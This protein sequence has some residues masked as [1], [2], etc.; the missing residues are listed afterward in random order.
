MAEVVWME[1]VSA[2]VSA[3]SFLNGSFFLGFSKSLS[4]Q[5]VETSTVSRT[6]NWA[7]SKGADLP[8]SDQ[9]LQNLKSYQTCQRTRG[10]M[11]WACIVPLFR[12]FSGLHICLH[13]FNSQL[14]SKW[15]SECSSHFIQR[16]VVPFHWAQMLVTRCVL[17]S[18][19][20][21]AWT[22]Y[23]TCYWE[24]KNRLPRKWTIS[25]L[26]LAPVFIREK[27]VCPLML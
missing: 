16:G 9:P 21:S 20:A 3:S 8:T 24:I 10:T 13:S 22:G 23:V 26:Y 6:E 4:S 17:R 7:L 2:C 12:V 14:R 18:C 27:S 15:V 11:T 5:T 1:D 19:T 25:G